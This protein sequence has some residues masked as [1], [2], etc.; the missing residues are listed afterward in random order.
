MT[1]IVQLYFRH[2]IEDFKLGAVNLVMESL[3]LFLV[4]LSFLQHIVDDLLLMVDQVVLCSSN[5]NS[6][7]HFWKM[8]FKPIR[9]IILYLFGLFRLFQLDLFIVLLGFHYLLYHMVRLFMSFQI[10]Q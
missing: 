3:C 6:F 1:I 4:H 10:V 7:Y 8:V 5:L 2:R 9:H